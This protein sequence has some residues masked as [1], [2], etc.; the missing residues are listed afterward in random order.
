MRNAN[1]F[2]THVYREA[3]LIYRITGSNAVGY[4]TVR[5]GNKI[6]MRYVS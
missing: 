1:M 5:S 3:D 6:I 4:G 2:I